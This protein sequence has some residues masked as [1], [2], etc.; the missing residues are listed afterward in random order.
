MYNSGNFGAEKRRHH[1]R[2][3]F[4][5]KNQSRLLCTLLVHAS[6]PWR[7]PSPS[8]AYPLNPSD[9]LWACFLSRP[10]SPM[11]FT[12]ALANGQTTILALLAGSGGAASYL[13][14]S[15]R[16]TTSDIT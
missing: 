16:A 6:S 5:Q 1:R 9:S 7:L 3:L 13:W 11:P 12:A 14:G 8:T 15:T 4:A 10:L 2:A